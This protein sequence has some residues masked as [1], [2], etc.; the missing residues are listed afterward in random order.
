MGHALEQRP[1]PGATVA[2]GPRAPHHR[3]R[4]RRHRHR[5]RRRA[6]VVGGGLLALWVVVV[7]ALLFSARGDLTGAERLLPEA[8]DAVAEGDLAAAAQL[9]VEA[10][11]RLR[12][13]DRAINNPIVAPAHLIP[14]LGADLRAVGTVAAG[15]SSVTS[16][17]IELIDA[18]DELP[19]GHAALIPSDSEVPVGH[20]RSLA[21]PLGAV[22]NAAALTAE[23]LQL[24]EPSGL[25]SSVTSGR[26]RMLEL[27]EPLAAQSHAAA[28]LA[29]HVPTFLGANG[30]RRYLLGASTP[31]ALGG[32]GGFIGSVAV[33]DVEGGRLDI[34]PF[35]TADSF[36][37]LEPTR[38]QPPVLQDADRWSRYGGTGDWLTLNRT[39][40]FPAA[41]RAMLTH[42]EATQGEAV[43]GLLVAD[44]FLLEALLDIVGPTEVPDR[45]EPLTPATVVEYVTNEAYG[46]YDTNDERQE[47]LGDVAS[48]ALG[49]FLEGGTEVAPVDGL[50][51]L[52]RAAAAGHLQVYATDERVQSAFARAGMTGELADPDG[53]LVSVTLNSGTASKVDYFGRHRI[54]HEVRLLADGSTRNELT[55]AIANEAPSEGQPEYV[56]GPTNPTLDAGDNLLNV[57]LHLARPAQFIET[58][59]AWGDLPTVTE[60]EL[61]HPVHDSWVRI[62]SGESDERRYQWRTPNAWRVTSAGNA[63]YELVLQVPPTVARMDVTIRVRIPEGL[64]V[65]DL[66]EGAEI[67]EGAV[68]WHGRV[69]GEDVRLPLE[70]RMS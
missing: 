64:E 9:A 3:H 7:A 28:G 33:L 32:T 23:R 57:S 36:P 37:V 52:G 41:A 29:E 39:P 18:L 12:S 5:R 17:T 43:D 40:H 60:T 16:A 49:R 8:R 70:F 21:A 42:W 35:A 2:D 47:V 63:A 45:T 15:G 66:P 4:R 27:T 24:A 56:I 68:V 44:P 13:A 69:R 53:D 14:L 1:S 25:F 59:D 26:D 58:P 38:L 65:V 46:E 48:S 34:G 62:P 10:D 54:D 31:A 19:G 30:P 61:G 11:D 20:I 67:S 50:A 55:L 22:A 6:I 51:K